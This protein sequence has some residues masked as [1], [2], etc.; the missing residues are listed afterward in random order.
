M[1]I[2]F[3]RV[4]RYSHLILLNAIYGTSDPRY[5]PNILVILTRLE[6]ET[7]PAGSQRDG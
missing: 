7:G 1:F 5:D 4:L 6:D 3:F 2:Y